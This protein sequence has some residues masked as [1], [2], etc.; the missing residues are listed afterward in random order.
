MFI[1]DSGE[2]PN[3]PD[4]A[5]LRRLYGFTRSEARLISL[6]ARG[7]SVEAAADELRMAFGLVRT[8]LQHIFQK[9][10][11]NRRGQLLSLLLNGPAAIQTENA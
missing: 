11:T 9:T 1:T 2:R 8:H 7:Q 4:E 3:M 6:L 5:A 10:E